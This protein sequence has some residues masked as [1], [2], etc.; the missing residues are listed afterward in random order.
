MEE[1]GAAASIATFL[2][3]KLGKKYTI[4]GVIFSGAILVYG[5]VSS[6][7]VIFTLYPIALSMFHKADLN[8]NL[9][10]GAMAAGCWSFA[11]AHFPGT[12]Q[13]VNVI[14]IPYLGT[15]TMA[16]PVLGVIMGILMV[17][18]TAA[19]FMYLSN[20]SQKK[21][22]HFVM[23]EKAM[24]DLESGAEKGHDV[25]TLKS[26][27]PI[28]VILITLNVLKF[29]V[30]VAMLLGTVV[31][32]LLFW[33]RIHGYLDI[34]TYATQGAAMAAINTGVI[35]G[36]GAAVQGSEGFANLVAYMTEINMSPY[37]SFGLTVTAIAA[38]SGSGTGGLTIALEALA[39]QYLAMGINP[40]PLHRLG[41][42]ASVGFDSLPHCG[43]VVTMLTVTGG[44]YKDT[45]LPIFINDLITMAVLFIGIVLAGVLYPF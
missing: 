13:T 15:D 40:Q 18:G 24:R 44:T 33:N 41:A 9:L 28:I 12:P 45:Y 20:K 6:L 7:V 8:R 38:A 14:P 39:P 25:S 34:M 29:D 43:A 2:A 3:E 30:L 37:W 27:I 17:I 4:L 22:E 32:I 26:I 21:G 1:S 35:V 16:A 31:C 5:G 10:P 36:Y 23:D 42:A 11:A 19:Y